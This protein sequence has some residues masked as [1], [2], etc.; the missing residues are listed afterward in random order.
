ML[1]PT[2]REEAPH[3]TGTPAV[4]VSVLWVQRQ[5]NSLLSG[6][7]RAP[8][9][10]DGVWGPQTLD[11]LAW[12]LTN[13]FGVASDGTKLG[14]VYDVVNRGDRSR[15]LMTVPLERALDEADV[16]TGGGVATTVGSIAV[17][18][19]AAAAFGI[20]LW[21]KSKGG[22]ARL[23]GAG[24]Y[25]AKTWKAKEA[26]DTLIA[27]QAAAREGDRKGAVALINEYRALRRSGAEEPFHMAD[28]KVD[29]LHAQVQP[30]R[31]AG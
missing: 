24:Y 25:T 28:D 15:V 3:S 6:T 27:A 8:V 11:T 23:G 5:L 10:E 22:R 30:W 18:G 14:Q 26:K 9:A 20:Y 19:A 1:D 13:V 29:R 31:F 16:S 17:W 2:R 12:Y 4:S 21:A 7:G